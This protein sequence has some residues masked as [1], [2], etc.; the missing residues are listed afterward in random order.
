VQRVSHET[1]SKLCCFV[2]V[3][4]VPP[5]I[6]DDISGN[7]S[8]VAN[9]MLTL[10]CPATGTPPP[11]ISWF[12]DRYPLSG[13]EV[14]VR[15]LPGG[16]LQ[17][18]HVQFSDAGQYTCVAE[19]AAGNASKDFDVQVFRELLYRPTEIQLKRAQNKL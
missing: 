1:L 6:Q 10:S 4:L 5:V 13:N 14:G 17:L 9:S 12:K 11:H 8:A 3:L 18:D 2:F 16:S 19:N 7:V 15:V